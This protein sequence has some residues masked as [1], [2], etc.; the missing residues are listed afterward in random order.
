MRRPGSVLAA[1][2]ATISGIRCSGREGQARAVVGLR[3][4][5]SQQGVELFRGIGGARTVAVD[6]AQV[7]AAHAAA[8]DQIGAGV[9]CGVWHCMPLRYRPFENWSYR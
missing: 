5:G 8:H 3:H 1:P 2:A 6:L 4:G 7:V 9:A